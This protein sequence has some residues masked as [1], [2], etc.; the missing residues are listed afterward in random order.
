[1]KELDRVKLVD[2]LRSK[3]SDMRTRESQYIKLEDN[4][5]YHEVSRKHVK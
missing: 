2:L 5:K 4:R 1:M 3:N